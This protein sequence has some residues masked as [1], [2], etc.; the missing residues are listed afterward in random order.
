MVSE[1]FCEGMKYFCELNEFEKYWVFFV[2]IGDDVMFEF[3]EICEMQNFNSL[4][5]VF[6]RLY[7]KEQLV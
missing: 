5:F 2:L 7:W 6:L 3:K 1:V 4:Y